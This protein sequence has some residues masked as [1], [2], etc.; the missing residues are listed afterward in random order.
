MRILDRYILSEYLYTLLGVLFVCVVVLLVYM[1]I[2][3]YDDILRNDPGLKYTTLFFLNSLPYNLMQVVP[4]SVAIATLFTVGLFSRHREIVAMVAAGISTRRIIAPLFLATLGVSL[5]TLFFNELVVPGC[6][7]R[8]RY[9]QKAFIEGKGKKIQTRSK[10]IFVKGQGQRFYVMDAF[11]SNTNVM[12]NPTV[13][14]L[15][16]DG[17]SLL[18]RMDADRGTLVK[19]RGKGNLW[20]FDNARRWEFD[21]LGRPVKFEKFDKPIT[22]EMEEDLEK[23]LS[24][25]K[26]PEEMNFFELRKYINIL[27]NRGESVGFYRTDLHLKLA[28]PFASLIIGLI[29]FCLA[30]RLDAR[31]MVLG[32]ALGVVFAIAY[33]GMTAL[34]QALGH[35]L[36]LP[37]PVSG[38]ISNCI[39][40]ALGVFFLHRLTI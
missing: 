22:L 17:S 6:Q 19:V 27:A 36:I 29:C 21:E 23:F 9:I 31:N 7:E 24:H 38:W 28:F 34:S 8:A 20:R 25:R 35:H 3:N 32:Y 13:I 33:Y 16:S 15:N 30:V 5:L 26:K 2:E 11:D 1:I 39:F 37:P 40:A 18:M 14:D 10:E 12:T 4:M